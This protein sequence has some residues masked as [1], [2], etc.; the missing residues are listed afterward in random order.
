MST[1]VEENMAKMKK[2]LEHHTQRLDQLRARLTRATKRAR[3]VQAHYKEKESPSEKEGIVLRRLRFDK[4]LIKAEAERVKSKKAWA[5]RL[6]EKQDKDLHS[7]PIHDNR[8]VE[9]TELVYR[10]FAGLDKLIAVD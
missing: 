8:V 7:R 4:N 5:Q 1:D 9:A 6:L 2:I 10:P 3:E